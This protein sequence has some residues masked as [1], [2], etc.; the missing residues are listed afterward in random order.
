M[1]RIFVI[2]MGH[3]H[4][5]HQIPKGTRCPLRPPLRGKNPTA[6][7]NF[8]KAVLLAAGYRCQWIDT[9]TGQRCPVTS[10]LEACHFDSYSETGIHDPSRGC[11]LCRPHHSIFDRERR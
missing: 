5:G 11:A 3:G 1:S 6:Q 4:P 8:R 10:P 7:Q 9:E 2:C